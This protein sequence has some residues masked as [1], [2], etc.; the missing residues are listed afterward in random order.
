MTITLACERY[1][2]KGSVILEK[3]CTFLYSNKGTVVLSK[4]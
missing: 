3:L 4:I 1:F 2:N